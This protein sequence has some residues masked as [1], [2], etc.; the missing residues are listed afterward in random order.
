MTEVEVA[1]ASAHQDLTRDPAMSMPRDLVPKN[2]EKYW[3]L[4]SNILSSTPRDNMPLASY[5]TKIRNMAAD[6]LHQLAIDKCAS[7]RLTAQA[8]SDQT[9]LDARVRELE[10]R[11]ANATAVAAGFVTPQ[12]YSKSSTDYYA[13]G[14]TLTSH[15]GP[16][17]ASVR[18]SPAITLARTRETQPATSGVTHIVIDTSSQFVFRWEMGEEKDQ[19]GFSWS[20]YSAV[21]TCWEQCNNDKA[22]P[23]RSFKTLVDPRFVATLCRELGILRNKPEATFAST[24]ENWDEISDTSLLTLI[25]EKLRPK[26]S[27]TF[28]LRMKQV[29]L[30][31][32]ETKGSL[33]Q[34]YKMFSD[35]FFAAVTDAQEAGTPIAEESIKS[36][37]R[38]VCNSNALL[39][40][41][42]GCM[43]KGSSVA[44]AHHQIINK[45][46]DSESADLFK[47]LSSINPSQIAQLASIKQLQPAEPVTASQP[48]HVLQQQ[49][50]Q[51]M[52]QQML[53]LQEL[54]SQLRLQQQPTFS[55]TPQDNVQPQRHHQ[56]NNQQHRYGGKQHPAVAMNNVLNQLVSQFEA[57]IAT[58]APSP[59]FNNTQERVAQTDRPAANH[60]SWQDQQSKNPSSQQFSA[61]TPGP[62]RPSSGFQ[63]QTARAGMDARG[64][65]WH[66][67]DGG[68]C[69]R[70]QPCPSPLF[71]QGCGTH[72]HTWRDCRR[73]VHSDWLHS[74]Y[75][76]EQRP[77]QKSL[78]YQTLQVRPEGNAQPQPAIPP[79][80]TSTFPTPF[81]A[82]AAS[83]GSRTP[84]SFVTR[85]NQTSSGGQPPDTSSA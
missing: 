53:Q 12:Q 46:K 16:S 74:G 35:K 36:A 34:R 37:F 65:S 73:M 10:S 15:E 5:R 71:C 8:A 54:Q 80:R 1:K 79:P 50:L 29:S 6:A 81:R 59:S 76:N 19:R 18:A 28:F 31:V 47:Q 42:L 14:A 56:P 3:E 30:C 78:S 58:T 21:K 63:F 33:N 32:D 40:M 23:Y 68:I 39:Q 77:N 7:A 75:W 72:G 55:Q 52:Q 38:Q 41:W 85:T 43:R 25:E 17:P 64:D 22:K 70:M 69:C 24:K 49:Q 60:S 44:E 83:T 67:P 51:L 13:A 82:N 4:H 26:D 45:L 48:G 84:T 61:K 62:A 20:A 57:R 66:H 9:A 2:L 11:A 27:T